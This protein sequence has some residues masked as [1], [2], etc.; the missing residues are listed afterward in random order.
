MFSMAGDFVHTESVCDIISI[1]SLPF[2]I[3]T[4]G[5][6][7]FQAIFKHHIF[8]YEPVQIFEEIVGYWLYL[9]KTMVM[10]ILAGVDTL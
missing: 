6:V 4:G 9:F 2:D 10:N 8:K 3:T 1:S 7:N 5:I